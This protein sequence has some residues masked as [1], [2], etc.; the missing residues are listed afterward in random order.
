MAD[1]KPTRKRGASLSISNI[2]PLVK[3]EY[4]RLAVIA[5]MTQAEF[6]R[7]LLSNYKCFNLDFSKEEQERLEVA[8][9]KTPSSLKNKIKR[10]ILR[11]VE[12]AINRP[13]KVINNDINARTSSHSANARVDALLDQILRHNETAANWYDKIFITKSSMQSYV[14]QQKGLNAVCLTPGKTVIDRCL[15][16]N[17]ELISTHHLEQGLDSSHNSKA[18][19]ARAKKHKFN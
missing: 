7:T 14:Q 9:Q 12:S 16:R 15:E 8:L 18:Y 19:Y 3:T 10:S 1:K 13:S 17:K 6:T 2:D 11:H 4:A 5:D